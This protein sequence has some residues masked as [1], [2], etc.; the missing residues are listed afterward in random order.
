MLGSLLGQ[1]WQLV[2][3]DFSNSGIEQAR[4]RW[5]EIRFEVGDVTQELGDLGQFDVVINTEVIEHVVLP[6]KL[7]RNCFHFLKPGGILV[8][9]TPYHGFLRNLAVAVT[10]HTDTHFGPLYDYGHIKFWS[11]DTLSKL[12]WQAG[13]EDLE[14]TGGAGRVRV[15]YLWTGFVMCARKPVEQ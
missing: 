10:N 2:G 5:P 11:V 15:P 1:G 9:S 6:R 3:V 4:K 14:Y 13:F 8:L 12:L 7:V